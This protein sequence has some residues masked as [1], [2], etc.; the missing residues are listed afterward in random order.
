VLELKASRLTSV[1]LLASLELL[2]CGP[3]PDV[4]EAGAKTTSA[5]PPTV[6]PTQPPAVVPTPPP[7]VVPPAAPTAPLPVLAMARIEHPGPITDI[8]WSGDGSRIATTCLL[9]SNEGEVRVWNGD[10]YELVHTLASWPSPP[11]HVGLSHDGKTL[12]A[13]ADAEV[14]VYAEGELRHTL[15]HG[16]TTDVAVASDA[17]RVAS[18]GAD[19]VRI[20]SDATLVHHV[21]QGGKQAMSV[22]FSLDGKRLA[23]GWDDGR[24][25]L[26]D[27]EGGRV[28][29]KPIRAGGELEPLVY[30]G[31]RLAVPSSAT[32]LQVYDADLA[33]LVSTTERSIP[34]ALGFDG[35][36][37]LATGPAGPEGPALTLV[38]ANPGLILRDYL[39]HGKAITAAVFA[40]DGT[41]FASASEDATVLIWTAP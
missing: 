25:R 11:L 13:H 40:A 37:L 1:W 30:D 41:R 28:V 36:L 20:W 27:V 38:D 31:R 34:L 14:R 21:E 8:A 22:V 39:G 3:S 4:V 10:S 35:N 26:I 29:G 24:V 9:S 16:A 23:S 15:S 32:H 33:K 5:P 6:V 18:S 7:A 19:G 12:V 17:T 2:A